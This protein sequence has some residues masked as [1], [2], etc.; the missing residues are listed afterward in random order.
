MTLD[1]LVMEPDGS[2]GPTALVIA[3][4]GRGAN[5]HDLVPLAQALALERVRYLFAEAPLSVP[6]SQD[7]RQWY[8]FGADHG[9]GVRHSRVL[10]NQL[11]DLQ[12]Q[13]F[14][15]PAERIALLGF[16]QGA[17]MVLDVGLQRTPH[18]AAL[19]AMSGYLFEGENIAQR[20]SAG[21]PEVLLVHGTEDTVIP[22]EASR[23]AQGV[24]VELGAKVQLYEVTMGH[25]INMSALVA[26]RAF[27]QRTLH[28]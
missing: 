3:L 11:I 22:V 5:R 6:G 7:G 23:L 9:S 20:S 26:V 28:L 18:P 14:N 16:S 19:V 21:F 10:L 8:E 1:V 4:H 2:A 27:L 13:K 24:L 15:T 12:S 17:V 25:Q